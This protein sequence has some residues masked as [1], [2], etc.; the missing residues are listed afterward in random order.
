ML[1][2]PKTGQ[3]KDGCM[4]YEKGIF[5][6]FSMYRKEGSEDFRSVWLATSSDGVH[7]EDRGCVVE[8]FPDFIWAMKVYRTKDAF[9]M[10]SGS[11]TRDGKQAILKLWRSEDLLHWEYCPELDVIAPNG[12]EKGARLDCM[13]VLEKDGRYYGYATGQY[14]FLTSEDGIRWQPNLS[15]MDYRPFPPYN[16]ALGGFEIADFIELDGRFY[17]FC[18]GFGHLGMSGYGVYLYE[19]DAPDGVFS[20][21]LPYYRLNGTSKR[22]V[23]MWERCFKKDGQI[24][25]HNY[26]YDG[27]SYE[28]GCVYLPPIKRLIRTDEKLCLGWWEGNDQLYGER[29]AEAPLLTASRQRIDVFSEDTESCEL[30]ELLALPEDAVIECKLTLSPN[31]FTRYSAGGIYL[32]EGEGEGSAILFDTYGRVEIAHIKDR[33]IDSVEDTVGFGSCAPYYVESG[34][35]YSLRIPVSHGMMEIYV[36]GL[37]LQTFNNAH[38][39]DARSS[40]FLGM[41]TVA[42]REGCTLSDV[43]VYRM[44]K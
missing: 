11:F 3:I 26:S 28:K 8:D 33:R 31:R 39:P 40:P 22:W 41:A 6:L 42:R 18:G 23:N 9:Y 24:L 5:Y 16:T 44:K 2:R 27:Y 36:D 20:P 37:Y 7:F 43:V 21:S 17:L 30:S 19:S 34:K 13:C 38:T 12:D 25:C 10:N 1:Y 15:R 29:V 4:I 35:T 14:G 32:S